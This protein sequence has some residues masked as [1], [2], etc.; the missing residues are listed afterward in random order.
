MRNKLL[1]NSL[2]AFAFLLFFVSAKSQINIPAS[3]V[4]SQN[5]NSLATGSSAVL[6]ENRKMSAPGRG[7]TSNRSAATNVTKVTPVANSVSSAGPYN[8]LVTRGTD[9]SIGFMNHGSYK[10]ANSL[11][12]FYRNKTGST[13]TFEVRPSAALTKVCLDKERLL[14]TDAG[15]PEC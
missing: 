14:K 12:A 2:S 15:P 10:G 6:P 3:G 8:S 9:K 7:N 4:V 1:Y 13:T 11:M 5:F